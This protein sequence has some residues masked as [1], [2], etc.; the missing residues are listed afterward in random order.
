MLVF[1]FVLMDYMG[2]ILAFLTIVLIMDIIYLKCR[3]II[4]YDYCEKLM[5]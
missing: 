2:C 3:D 1:D 4:V 5:N